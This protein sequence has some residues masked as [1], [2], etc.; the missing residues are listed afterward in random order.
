MKACNIVEQSLRYRF[1][2]LWV[3]VL[4]YLCLQLQYCIISMCNNMQQSFPGK[5]NLLFT[6]VIVPCWSASLFQQ[7]S[8]NI[9]QCKFSPCLEAGM[10]TVQDMFSCLLVIVPSQSDDNY[11]CPMCPDRWGGASPRQCALLLRSPFAFH[12]LRFLFYDFPLFRI[13]SQ[14]FFRRLRLLLGTKC[15]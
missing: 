14:N 2:V 10:L 12:I 7:S 5:S 9:M 1:D 3:S 6:M 11:H 15:S 4:S 8:C 13:Q